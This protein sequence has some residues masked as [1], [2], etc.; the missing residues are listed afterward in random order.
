MRVLQVTG[1][2]AGGV[3]RHAREI[4]ALLAAGERPL[5]TLPGPDETADTVVL[6]GPSDVVEPLA[7][8]PFRGADKVRTAVVD[9][10]D[11]PRPQDAA[12]VVRLRGLAADADVVHAHGLR[13]GALTV[14]ALA[15]LPRRPR[16]VVTLHN[17][18][19]GG[20]RVTMV[21]AVLERI[22]AHGA[23]VVLGVSGDI[24]TRMRGRGA[25]AVDRALVPAP[26]RRPTGADPAAVRR[27]LGLADGEHLALTVAR[28]APQKGLDLLLDAAALVDG[29]AQPARPGR[30]AASS[31][32]W[33]WA[34]AGDGPLRDALTRRVRAEELPVLLAGRRDDV[35]D[36]LAAADV[37]VS[38][39]TWEG[40]PIAVQEALRAGAAIVATDVGGTREVTGDAAVLVPGGDAQAL[41]DAVRSVLADPTRQQELRDRARARAAELPRPAD[42]RAQLHSVY[43]AADAAGR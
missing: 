15:T 27:S 35:P 17:L 12:A 7:R 16:L 20:P 26:V 37:V 21:A 29:P 25:R 30:H 39:A 3:G 31:P 10:A 42:V 4:S 28:L 22:V 9:I 1:S 23:D 24:V 36:L 32:G 34:V 5:G 40:Q 6:A 41:A 43:R 14:M 38:T 13:A 33:R 2:S 11:R 18:P 8:E 19:V